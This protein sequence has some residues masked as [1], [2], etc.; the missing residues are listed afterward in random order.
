LNIEKSGYLIEFSG[1]IETFHDKLSRLLD[2]FS[3]T[4]S[5]YSLPESILSS[6]IGI[7]K[8][9]NLTDDNNLGQPV[10]FDFSCLA[11]CFH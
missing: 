11:Y 7:V 6:R 2:L 10:E 5:N 1:D 9:P 3:A 8:P 4:N